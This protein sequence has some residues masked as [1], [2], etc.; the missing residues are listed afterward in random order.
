[1]I[2]LL[3][4]IRYEV[5]NSYISGQVKSLASPNTSNRSYNSVYYHPCN[6]DVES[7]LKKN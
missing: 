6:K 1:M 4:E 3:H 5:K 2:K 7:L